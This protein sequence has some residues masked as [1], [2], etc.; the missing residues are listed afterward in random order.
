MRIRP[1]D[2]LSALSTGSV[3][4]VTPEEKQLALLDVGGR[5]VDRVIDA[6]KAEGVEASPFQELYMREQLRVFH[7]SGLIEKR[8]RELRAL[9]RNITRLVYEHHKWRHARNG[10]VI[11]EFCGATGSGKSSAMLGLLERLNGVKPERLAKHLTIDVPEIP[12]LLPDI[13]RGSGIAID[14]QTHAVGEGSITQA[15]TL[16]N[17]EDQIRI[18]GK[19]IYWASPEAQDHATSQGQFVSV[20]T[21][22]NKRYTRFLVYLNDVPLGYANLPWCS[23]EMWAAYQPLKDANAKRAERA[24]FQATAVM[25]EHV[26]R[27]FETP[28]VLAACRIRRLKT[29]DWKRLVKRHLTTL[30]TSQVQSLAEE[31]EFMLETIATRPEDFETIYGWQPTPGMIDAAG[32]APQTRPRRN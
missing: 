8:I 29:S 32:G 2:K 3:D 1:S 17:L 19:D 15:R 20:F 22:F 10:N 16:R 21:H 13:P 18:T 30:N 25:D 11:W 27:L 6:H 31:L 5:L 26:R 24:A 9:E 12:Y 7:E 28:A 14:E 4:D 23:D